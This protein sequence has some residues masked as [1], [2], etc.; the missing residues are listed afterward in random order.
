MQFQLTTVQKKRKLGD[1]LYTEEMETEEQVSKD[2]ETHL[3]KPYILMLAYAIAGAAPL[4]GVTDPSKEKTLIGVQ[5][6]GV[7]G[8]PA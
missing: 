8:D 3:A 6:H 1:N 4:T 5:L 7:C 2:A